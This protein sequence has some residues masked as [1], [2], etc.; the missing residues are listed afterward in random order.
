M[1]P[2]RKKKYGSCHCYIQN[3]RTWGCI[4]TGSDF[5]T[6]W[7]TDLEQ[8]CR[9]GDE[10]GCML[11]QQIIRQWS[12]KQNDSPEPEH[13]KDSKVSFKWQLHASSKISEQCQSEAWSGQTLWWSCSGTIKLCDDW[14]RWS[15]DGLFVHSI[16]RAFTSSIEQYLKPE[17]G[18]LKA[19]SG[20]FF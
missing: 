12:R 6:Y 18:G 5:A 20:Y 2:W 13:I 4:Y 1:T 7:C 15:V 11:G 17:D 8:V 3:R 19:F 14:S 10:I 16:W 9:I